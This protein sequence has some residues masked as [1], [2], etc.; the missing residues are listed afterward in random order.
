[1]NLCLAHVTC[2]DAVDDN[3]NDYNIEPW[4]HKPQLQPNGKAKSRAK[5]RGKRQSS[6]CMF[7]FLAPR[8][9]NMH[10]NIHSIRYASTQD[11]KV[12]RFLL[13]ICA[14]SVFP[15][16]F[17]DDIIL[18]AIRYLYMFAWFIIM[19]LCMMLMRESAFLG[20]IL[21]EYSYFSRTN[22]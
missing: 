21:E 22:I 14:Q 17:T 1:M 11:E 5:N 7:V 8:W 2:T 20:G 16:F 6:K 9:V 15:C 18:V 19:N 12:N 13:Y 3:I 10:T 4:E